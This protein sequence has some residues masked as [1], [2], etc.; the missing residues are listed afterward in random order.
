MENPRLSSLREAYGNA[1]AEIGADEKI[2]V[3]DADTPE[4]TKTSIFAKKYPE[5][6]FNLGCAEQNMIGVA[7]GLATCGKTVFASAFAMFEIG[8]G[9]EQI[10]NMIAYNKLSVKL[11]ATHAG[12]TVGEDGA[13]HQI[14]ED[15]AL[16]RTLP[17]MKVIVPADAIQTKAVIPSIAKEKGPA[18]VRICRHNV[19]E[20]FPQGYKYTPEKAEVLRTGKDVAI[21]STGVMTYEALKA[22]EALEKEKISCAV[23]NVHTIKPIDKK[24]IVKYAKECGAVVTAEEHSIYG[25]LGGAIA[26]V[27]AQ[28]YPV[29]MRMAGVQDRF[30]KSGKPEELMELYGLTS[31][32]IISAA[33]EA[34]AREDKKKQTS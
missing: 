20:I 33:K 22:A 11:V 15:I 24:T 12:I 8:R 29:P 5:R 27:L 30:G 19:P 9:W 3:L 28:E 10:R 23:I 26:E 21:F 7:A 18:Y 4:S 6:F 34:L 2:V 17:N 13:S 32:N 31:K 1:L 16:M 25:G 14:L